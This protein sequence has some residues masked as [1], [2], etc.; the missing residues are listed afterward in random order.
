MT[1]TVPRSTVAAPPPAPTLLDRGRALIARIPRADG[2][3]VMVI[4][5]VAM[6]LAFTNLGGAPAYQDD[7]GIYTAQA[8]AVQQ[9]HL[10]PYTYWY[11]HPP[12]GWIQLAAFGWLPRLIGIG[13]G[14]EIAA[15]RSVIALYFVATAVLIYLLARRMRVALP[16]AIVASAAMMLSPLSLELSRQVYLDSIGMPWLL[17][18]LYLALS[19]R[20]A[21][22]HHAA[23]GVAFAIAVLTK[24]T[25]AII[26][27]ALL[28]AMIDRPRWGGRSFSVVS[29]LAA[30]GLVLMFFPLMAL[31]RGELFAG[32]GHVSLT[33]GLL[34]QFASRPGSG[35]VWEVGSGRHNLV[36]SWLS[37]DGFLVVAGGVAAAVCL[38]SRRTRWVSVAVVSFAVPIAAGQGYLPAMYIVGGIPFLCIAVGAAADLVWRGARVAARRW[39]PGARISAPTL[40]ALVLI[41]TLLPIP[42]AAWAERDR[43][44]VTEDTNAQWRQTLEWVEQNLD[45]DDVILVPFSLWPDL[46]N[47][48]WDGPWTVVALEKADLD[49]AFLDEHPGG[50]RDIDWIIEGP[51]VLPTIGYLGLTTAQSA[52]DNST[53]VARFGQWTVREVT[54]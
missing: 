31:L 47:S 37:I 3:A 49:T 27:P 44:L 22:W 21:L 7:E 25:A 5:A 24:L 11:D 23:S 54:P 1:T 50:W 26:G 53:V 28:V 20:Q 45:R 29:F 19:P 4:A 46:E 2:I 35:F 13:D 43:A 18:A 33:E 36:T 8:V 41:L 9:G 34:Y 51:T 14:S 16:F 17:L 38:L 42:L 12:L 40:T 32:P 39:V 30:G 10:A 6:V 52:I 15:M 48:G